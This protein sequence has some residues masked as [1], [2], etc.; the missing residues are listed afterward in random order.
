MF[1]SDHQF[2]GLV[3]EN[4]RSAKTEILACCYEWCWYRGQR[5]GTA[6]DVN[7]ALATRSSSGLPVFVIL[8]HEAFRTHISRINR[9]T[10]SSLR[11]YHATVLTGT[12]N[13]IIH[14]KFWL[15]DATT[16]I[17]CTHNISNR[18]VRSNAEVGIL[19][20]EPQDVQDARA[21][22]VKLWLSLPLDPSAPLPSPN[23]TE[24]IPTP[25]L[26]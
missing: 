11:R 1:F 9:V 6:Q 15:F 24:T 7:R 20:T 4:I 8:H 16:L 5:A 3:C 25:S 22:F 21:Y 26:V 23:H 10:A 18:A 2:L 19:T 14:A 17:V 13:R 12:T